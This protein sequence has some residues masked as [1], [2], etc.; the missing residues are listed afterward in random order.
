M[1]KRN[2]DQV[3]AFSQSPEGR[4]R[5]LALINKDGGAIY[6]AAVDAPELILKRLSNG[7]TRRGR[8]LDGR[9]VPLAE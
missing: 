2:L 5:A 8:W 1:N 3:V 7:S 4:A 6:E 9:F